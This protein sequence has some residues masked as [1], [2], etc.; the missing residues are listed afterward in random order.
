MLNQF[1]EFEELLS[2]LVAREHS[3]T[4]VAR[5]WKLRM[6]STPMPCQPALRCEGLKASRGVTVEHCKP[7]CPGSQCQRLHPL[8]CVSYCGATQLALLLHREVPLEARPSLCCA[9]SSCASAAAS[10]FQ[11]SAHTQDT[12]TPFC[13]SQ[14]DLPEPPPSS[15]V[16]ASAFSLQGLEKLTQVELL[17]GEDG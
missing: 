5:T 11:T 14:P 1:A 4:S 13:H 2:T 17:G 8:V 15:A 16:P 3:G 7:V 6:A 9:S 10:P 12:P